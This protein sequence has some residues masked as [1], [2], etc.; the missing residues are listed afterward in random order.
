MTMGALDCSC[1]LL[2]WVAGL[3]DLV[4]GQIITILPLIISMITGK[5]L[6]FHPRSS[7]RFNRTSFSASQVI[8]AIIKLILIRVTSIVIYEEVK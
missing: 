8:I 3:V 5:T 7:A 6:V 4:S 2:T 1:S